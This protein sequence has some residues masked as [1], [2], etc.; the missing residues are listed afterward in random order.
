MARPSTRALCSLDEK[1][2]RGISILAQTPKTAEE[3]LLQVSSKWYH[4]MFLT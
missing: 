4:T 2:R 3:A 1:V